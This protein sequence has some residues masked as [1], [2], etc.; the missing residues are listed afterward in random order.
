MSDGSAKSPTY[1]VVAALASLL[2]HLLLLGVAGRI[3]V[4]MFVST[5]E[6]ARPAPYRPVIRVFPLPKID[7]TALGDDAAAPGLEGEGGAD[8]A[9]RQYFEEMQLLAPP[10]PKLEISGLGGNVV[11]PTPPAAEA[12]VFPTAPRPEILA[13]ADDGLSPE[14]LLAR[15]QTAA[16]EREV[17]EVP[18]LPSLLAGGPL[19]EGSLPSLKVGMRLGGVPLASAADVVLPP[20]SPPPAVDAGSSLPDV[21]PPMAPTLDLEPAPG[22][23]TYEALDALLTVRLSTYLPPTGDGYFKIELLPNPQSGHL[24]AIA[25]DILILV[26]SSNSIPPGKLNVF[27]QAAEYALDVLNRGDR[28]NVVSFRTR[29]EPLFPDYV[30]VSAES[31]A[32]GKEFLRRLARG[33]MTDVY[34]SLAPFVDAA[35]PAGAGARPLLVYLLTD[36]ESTVRNRLDNDQ[37]LR[38]IATINRA[39]VTIYSASAG[40]GANRFL[41]DLLAYSNRG[42]PLHRDEFRSYDKVLAQFIGARNDILVDGLGYTLATD[43][44]REV[45]PKR[46][47][48]LYR[49]DTLAIYGRYPRELRQLA[50]RLTGR[51]AD[52]R[53]QEL[54]YQGDLAS[55]TRGG[56]EL[57]YEW[58]AQKVFYL[59]IQNVLDPRPELAQEIRRLKERYDLQIPYF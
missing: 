33:G 37:F 9:V 13:L 22:G 56:A 55:A 35:R 8:L 34:A 23:E 38:Q 36:G 24:R 39:D 19:S 41:L 45:Y 43:I 59:V 18:H 47:P 29:A 10:K 57:A 1:I 2:V 48:H 20:L 12:T 28:F 42:L 26:D 49:G 16:V 25:K 3:P 7:E 17:S 31:I 5:G 50:L 52:G 11:L 54:V 51:S 27:K 44:E 58:I 53:L 46:L 15:A 40:T 21:P 30:P 4:A 14:D 6:V 32:Q